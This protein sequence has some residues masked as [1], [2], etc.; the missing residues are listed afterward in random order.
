MLKMPKRQRRGFTESKEGAD[1]TDTVNRIEFNR[2][3]ND[4]ITESKEALRGNVYTIEQ[5][6]EE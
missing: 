2:V 1:Y 5:K 6:S 3:S 4:R